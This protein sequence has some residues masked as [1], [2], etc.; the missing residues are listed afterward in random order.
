[1]LHLG[2]AAS[3]ARF[4]SCSIP[5]SHQALAGALSVA[6]NACSG[7][8]LRSKSG[9]RFNRPLCNILFSPLFSRLSC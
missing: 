2:R 3:A 8:N 4:V 9:G 1:M 6:L 7:S 5:I